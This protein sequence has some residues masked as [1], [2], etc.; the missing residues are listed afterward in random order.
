MLNFNSIDNSYPMN[1][2]N[3]AQVPTTQNYLNNPTIQQQSVNWARAD[4]STSNQ[5]SI[6]AIASDQPLQTAINENESIERSSLNTMGNYLQQKGSENVKRFSVNNLLQ[7]ANNCR[8][9]ANEQR[10]GK[11][12]CCFFFA[13]DP[14]KLII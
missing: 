10:T 4:S 1:S 12:F 9:L 2:G 5:I 13:D 8:A 7:L 11:I 3:F 6:E 14:S